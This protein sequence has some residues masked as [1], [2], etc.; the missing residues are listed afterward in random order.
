MLSAEGSAVKRELN[1]EHLI[2]SIYVTGV[3]NLSKEQTVV[4]VPPG[5]Q[6][7]PGT[8]V[9]VDDVLTNS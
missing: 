8:G 2:G 4:Q 6:V 1:K 7:Q 9:G 3:V 5:L